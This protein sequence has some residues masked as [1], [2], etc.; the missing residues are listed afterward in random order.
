M[1][2]VIGCSKNCHQEAA[3][4]AWRVHINSIG[5]PIPL[6]PWVPPFPQVFRGC[7]DVEL[8]DVA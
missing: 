7:V 8:G 5:V 1:V 6:V 2:K 4:L 3:N